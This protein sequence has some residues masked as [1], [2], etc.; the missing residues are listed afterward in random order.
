[1]ITPMRVLLSGLLILI[2]GL[3]ALAQSAR[4][5]ITGLVRDATGAVVPG[6]DITITEKATSVVTRTVST[7]AGAYRA[8]YIPPGTYH[9][10]ASLAGFKTA[11]ADNIQVLVGQ[12]VTV[13]FDL[14][15]G[16]LSDQVTV[17]AQTPLL[18]ASNPEIGINTTEKEVTSR[19]VS[20]SRS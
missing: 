18:E 8:P 13:D 16:Q 10:T 14:E 20:H 7:E 3:P 11:V 19:V 1:M 2:L 17:M 6:V 12:T 4:G 9:I 15:I 5:T